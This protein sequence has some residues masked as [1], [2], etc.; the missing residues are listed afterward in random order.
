[1]LKTR[2]ITLPT[3]RGI[4]ILL[5]FSAACCRF[6]NW[7]SQILK[8]FFQ[9]TVLETIDKLIYEHDY[10]NQLSDG[11]RYCCKL[12]QHVLYL[13]KSGIWV[14]NIW[15]L[16]V[17]H[18]HIYGILLLIRTLPFDECIIVYCNST[19]KRCKFNAINTLYIDVSQTFR[20]FYRMELI[21][22]MYDNSINLNENCYFDGVA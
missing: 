1:M 18:I 12:V 10:C 17:Y 2:Y 20:V 13:H 9:N 16:S 19:Y 5:G 14:L 11:P 6:A 21:S 4:L 22:T 15:R 8:L 7:F 3:V